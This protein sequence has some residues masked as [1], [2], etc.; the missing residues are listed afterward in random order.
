MLKT[1][2]DEILQQ[3]RLLQQEFDTEFDALL[4]DGRKRFHY[5][6]TR[7]RVVFENGMRSLHREQRTG[8]WPYIK[9]A[10]VAFILTAPVIYGLLIPLVVL[11]L[12]LTV[13]QQIC[14]RVYGIARVRRRDYLVI[15]RHRLSYLNGIEKAN[16]LYC[17]YTNQ[18]LEYAREIAGRTEQFWCPIKHAR[19]TPDP[20]RRTLN[21]VHYGDADGYVHR[22]DYLR[23]DLRG[24]DNARGPSSRARGEDPI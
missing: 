23:Q 20:H 21:F 5:T 8:I 10:P 14:F 1:R 11:D 17:G 2:F 3:L 12:A 16:C 6:L 9:A 7:G 24:D 22:L 13:Y 18:L 4:A 19:R 15:D